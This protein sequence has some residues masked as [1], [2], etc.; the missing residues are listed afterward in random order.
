LY[1]LTGEQKYFNQTLDLE[2][3]PL[4]KAKL[5]KKLANDLKDKG[6]YSQARQYY[7]E[8]M[9]LNPSDGSPHLAIAAMY[10]KSANSCGDS[11]FNKRAVFWLAALEA[12]KAGRVDGRLK[13][14]SAKSAASYRAS[15]PSTSDIF[16]EGNAGQT[17]KIGCWIGRSVTVPNI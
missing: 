3:D 10:A 12:E 6:S 2:S 14:A 4:K 16:T 7:T 9:K 8:S 13:S 5:Y 11:N 17:I 15:A 1:L